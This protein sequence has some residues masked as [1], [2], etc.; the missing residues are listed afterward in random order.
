MKLDQVK[1]AAPIEVIDCDILGPVKPPGKS[2]PAAEE[3]SLKLVECVDAICRHIWGANNELGR[4]GSTMI[5]G[6]LAEI[7]SK[8]LHLETLEAAN[9]DLDDTLELMEESLFLMERMLSRFPHLLN[10]DFCSHMEE[11]YSHLQQWGMGEH[12]PDQQETSILSQIVKQST[13]K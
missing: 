1:T 4:G 8:K 13:D 6:K 12:P 2:E 9:E 7:I 10:S 11:I 5:K 3:P